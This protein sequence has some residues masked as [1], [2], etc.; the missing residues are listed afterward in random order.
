MKAMS[1]KS[2]TWRQDLLAK[3]HGDKRDTYSQRV[4]N[5][6]SNTRAR[7]GRSRETYGEM[8]GGAS[9]PWTALVIDP[10]KNTLIGYWDLVSCLALIFTAVVTPYEV[11]F[12]PAPVGDGKWGDPLFLMN[13]VIDLIFV[14][15]MLLQFFVATQVTDD[16]SGTRW[17][18]DSRAIVVNYVTSR[19]FYL[20]FFSIGT[21][22]F[23][24]FGTGEASSL[25]ALRVVRALRLVKLVRLAR[26]SRMLTRYEKRLN[27]N[28]A[29]LGLVQVVVTLLVFCHW[30]A[31][32]WGLQ[33]SFHRLNSWM[34]A[35][36]YCE[37]LPLNGS[38]VP[39]ATAE[40]LLA[41][42]PAEKACEFKACTTD[43][44]TRG[45]ICEGPSAACIRAARA[46]VEPA[47]PRGKISRQAL[48]PPLALPLHCSPLTL[49]AHSARHSLCSLLAAH[50]SQTCTRC[51]GRWS[52]S[53]PS[54]TGTSTPSPS[55][56]PSS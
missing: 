12:V 10:R 40:A 46:R 48:C 25:S 9:K 42:C 5:F 4:S 16:R 43:T 17:V 55:T 2:Q 29:L 8:A 22:A 3:Y 15:D 11:G 33:A 32:V 54:A 53:P 35:T 13:R 50:R 36:G 37:P 26:G 24:L 52:R 47:L 19:W 49:A 20:D 7:M 41:N 14:A 18:L 45:S 27:I 23:D 39:R 51:T 31:C 1:K 28:Y 44:C 38:D 34:G 56:R 6:R 30:S 21:S